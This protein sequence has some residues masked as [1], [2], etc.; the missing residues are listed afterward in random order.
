MHASINTL[1]SNT[2]TP[3]TS[4]KPRVL[5]WRVVDI[6][7][8]SVIGVAIGLVYFAWDQVYSPVTAPLEIH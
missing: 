2:S 3:S 7:V 6:V 1:S 5:K 8:A 4:R